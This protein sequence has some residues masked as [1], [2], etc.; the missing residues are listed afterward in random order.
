[1]VRSWA[2]RVQRARRVTTTFGRVYLG[3]KAQQ[4]IESRLRPPDMSE[5]WSDFHRSSAESIHAT[6]VELHGLVLKGC[7]FLGARADVLPR[8]YVEV[9]GRLQ[10]RV[11][12]RPFSVVRPLVEQELGA[13]LD[14]VFADFARVPIASASLA[15]VH[16]ARLRDGRRVAV[17][18]Q[19]PEV[20]GQ[21][22]GDLANLRALFQA[23]DFLEREID[24]MPL[25]DELGTHVPLELDF[26]N[27]ARN[28]ELVAKRLSARE[29]V[30]VPEIVW[31][32][33]TTRVLV[34]E[35]LEGIK[36]N[37]VESLRAAGVDL[38]AVGRS[39]VEVFA[40]QI[41]GHGFFHADP[42][43]GNVLVQPGG[44]RLVLLDF[45]LAKELPLR[46]REGV[47]GFA[48]GIL[49]GDPVALGR[50]LE[51]L[52]FE[53]RSADPA[54]LA[55][56]AELVL[57]ATRE[58]QGG[59]ALDGEGLARL[60]EQILDAVRRDPIVRIPHHL[61]LV[62]RVLGLLSGVTR[63]LEARID[64]L[65]AL[66]PHALGQRPGAG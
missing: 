48:M 10:D 23:V 8:E 34:M 13:P 45:G 64:L 52:G 1:M 16:E 29:D 35:F 30:V 57:G 15:Q 2:T 55:A 49:A 40:E 18:V 12:A 62:G 9:L 24:L 54:S 47:M 39:L 11:P 21:V 65:A 28:A 58:L 25:V 43:P 59:A 19:Y 56:L 61:V 51:D 7:Q 44:P 60:R 6:A 31:E 53:T 22:Q 14:A 33:T 20:A 27:E 37:D 42:H 41:L 17:K 3:A 5:R 46:F 36:I 38:D 26:V 50:A 66:L 4:L 63:S 32:H